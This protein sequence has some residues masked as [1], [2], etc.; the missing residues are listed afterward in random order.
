[1]AMP[2]FLRGSKKTLLVGVPLVIA[3]VA[4]GVFLFTS[5]DDSPPPASANDATATATA[6]PTLTPV[7]GTPTATPTPTPV[8]YANILN[9]VIMPPAQF[10][11]RKNLLPVAIMID[12]SGA[13]YP[14]YGIEKA[15]VV[16]EAL[17]ESGIT[18]LMAVF[19]SQEA[20]IVEPVRSARTPFVIW[21]AELGALYG[22]AGSADTDNDANAG[23]QII[24]WGIRDLNAFSPVSD[25]AYYRDDQ[26]YAP[27]NLATATERLRRAAA[28]LN[29]TGSPAFLPYLFK[30]DFAGT[31]SAPAAAG[32]EV[33]F[34]ERRD[35]FRMTRWHY[36]AATNSYLRHAN[37][38][39][40]IDAVSRKQQS[41]K[42][43]IVQ[44]AQPTTLDTG[45]VVYDQYGTGAVTIFMD[46]RVIE[47]TWRKAD[48][49]ARTRYYDAA[50]KEIA[51]NR[52]P[53]FIHMTPPNGLLTIAATVAELPP[54]TFF[55]SPPPSGGG[56]I[57]LDDDPPAFATP[58]PTRPGGNASSTPTVPGSSTPQRTGTPQP[59]SPTAAGSATPAT[60]TTAI[61]SVTQAASTPAT[62]PTVP[63]AT[64]ASPATA[65]PS[66]TAPH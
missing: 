17:V 5:S 28:G 49:L 42:T 10:E 60:S 46:G 61:P 4:A 53:I 54:M 31:A 58:T 66:A 37:A 30:A 23:G 64:S 44:R 9:G 35:I 32:I 7:P 18:R 20:E 56:F 6:T 2:A 45:H 14:H 52:G 22:H 63:P 55:D 57:E 41:F 47:G 62:T 11:A 43:V 51:L 36:D 13:A 59:A 39:V 33:N 48:R 19:W 24:E 16:Y 21:V 1:M 25:A 29:Y 38:G 8:P 40:A 27:H 3:V 50:G 12:N 26:R 15:D 34:N 65:I